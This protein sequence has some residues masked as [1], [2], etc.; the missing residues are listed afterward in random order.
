MPPLS[1]VV[2]GVSYGERFMKIGERFIQEC[3]GNKL[4][5][6]VDRVNDDGTVGTHLVRVIGQEERDIEYATE[7]DAIEATSEV[8]DAPVEAVEKPKPKT[9]TTRKRTT[10]TKTTTRKKTT[11]KK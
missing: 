7:I 5:Y 9:T 10:S 2:V 8:A 1:F 6:E 4:E 3:F 11:T